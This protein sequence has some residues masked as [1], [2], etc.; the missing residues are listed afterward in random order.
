MTG[1]DVRPTSGAARAAL[2]TGILGI[3]PVSVVCAVV[4]LRRIRARGEDGRA[5]AIAAL[6]I[7]A[8]WTV[9]LVAGITYAVTSAADRDRAGRIVEAGSVDV[10]ELRVGDCL[11]SVE[12]DP[13]SLDVDA[14]PCGQPHEAQA[15]AAFDLSGEAWPGKD[16]IDAAAARGC[17]ERAARAAPS[18]AGDPGAFQYFF[19]PPEGSWEI[20]DD[21]GVTCFARYGQPRTGSV[22]E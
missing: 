22:V 1:P 9:V 2:V 15:Y 19:T 12:I 3:V 8:V 4:A 11:R 21:R 20:R 18:V 5:L 16:R 10:F 13:A 6:V 14:V 7:S 17:E